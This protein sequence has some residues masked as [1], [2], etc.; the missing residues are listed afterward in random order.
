MKQNLHFF[1]L[2][3]LLMLLTACE[4]GVLG[5]RQTVCLEVR[6]E[7]N[8]GSTIDR[9]YNNQQ[10]S[11]IY[12]LQNGNIQ[13][14]NQFFYNDKGQ[15]IE[16]QYYNLQNSNESPPEIISYNEK[17]N[18]IKSSSTYANGDEIYYI[19]EYNAQNQMKKLTSSSRRSGAVTLNFT[20]EYEWEGSN[21][22]KRTY[23]SSA[24][25][26]VIVYEFDLNRQNKRRKEQE[27]IAFMSLTVAHNR[28]MYRRQT[29]TT[30]DIASGRVT[31]T[32]S[33][34]LYEYN[35]QGYPLQLTRTST[36]NA[37]A[38]VTNTTSFYYDC[39]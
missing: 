10:L 18:W 39:E 14:Y 22:V 16:N 34:F 5:P 31:E 33:D 21:N 35:S 17:G 30:T 37:A 38:P 7:N 13:Y 32:V 23:V 27:K 19:I 11:E 1:L 20:I 12:V 29:T 15:V 36:T 25:R 24:M 26:Q 9:Q 4:E 8:S 28:N 3:G 6:Q 2:F